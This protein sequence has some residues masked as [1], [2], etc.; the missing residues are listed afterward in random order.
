M[1]SLSRMNLSDNEKLLF[2]GTR[3]PE[4]SRQP[5]TLTNRKQMSSTGKSS[6][7]LYRCSEEA[8]S[9]SATVARPGRAEGASGNWYFRPSERSKVQVK[10]GGVKHF[11][12]DSPLQG[13]PLFRFDSRP[14]LAPA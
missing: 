14:D 13:H 10:P 12:C 9:F 2:P 4:Y 7:Y 3:R 8:E 1:S 11:V 6:G 5:E